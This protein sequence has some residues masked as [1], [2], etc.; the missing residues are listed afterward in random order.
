MYFNLFTLH[1][2]FPLLLPLITYPGDMTFVQS[3]RVKDFITDLHH[4]NSKNPDDADTWNERTFLK[5]SGGEWE[6]H[7]FM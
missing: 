7:S 4:C 3:H 1:L 2:S 5:I 6:Y